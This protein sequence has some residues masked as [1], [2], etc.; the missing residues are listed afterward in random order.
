MA[1]A[2]MRP[3]RKRILIVE[4]DTGALSALA[5]ALGARYDVVVARDGVE[6]AEVAAKSPPDLIITDVT[7]PRLDG[8]GMVR[9][10]REQQAAKVPVIFV[11]AL[12]S[13]MAVVAGIA[14]G[15]RHYLTKPLDLNDLE[16]RI[17]R[18]LGE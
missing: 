1:T 12:D 2:S 14:A 18:V 4:D 9:R 17:V 8:I 11:S 5:Y 13:P 7:M 16:K 3:E 6:G 15:A 10:I